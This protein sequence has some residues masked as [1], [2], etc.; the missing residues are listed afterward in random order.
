MLQRI[1]NYSFSD[2]TPEFIFLSL[3]ALILGALVSYSLALSGQSWAKTFSNTSTYCLLPLI[4]FVI[5][6][7]ISGD[8]AL[9]LGMVGALSIIR[10]RHPVKS[11]LELSI[12]FLLLTLGITLTSSVGKAFI[13]AVI[14]MTTIYIF[15]FY[16]S[17]KMETMGG[18][19]ALSL[20]TEDPQYI[21]DIICSKKNPELS[22]S[23]YLLFSHENNA[24]SIY[25][26][27]LA[28]GDKNEADNM[29]KEIENLDN[30]DEVKYSCV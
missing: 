15:A 13:L 20:V 9:S 29:K 7:V 24:T 22:N 17:R 11:P 3:V 21:I 28:F 1:L 14:S 10:F 12:Y 26:Y 19:P 6:S 2:V 4:G 8:I 5:S 27:K 16:R 18:F 30:I 25:T 23:I